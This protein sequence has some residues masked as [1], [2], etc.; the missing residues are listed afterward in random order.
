MEWCRKTRSKKPFLV[1]NKELGREFRNLFLNRLTQLV[2][3]GNIQLEDSCYIADLLGDLR[4][5]DWVAFIEGPPKQDCPPSVMLKYLTR[6]LTGGPISDRRIV[7]EKDGRVYFMARSKR[8]SEGQVMASLSRV[9]FVQQWCLHILPKDFTKT[10]FFGAW[11]GSKRRKYTD[12]CQAL[13]PSVI[14]PTLQSSRGSA[15]KKLDSPSQPTS[16]PTCP[17]CQGSMACIAQEDRPK[18][19]ELFYGPAHPAWYEWTSLG[20]CSP[21]D[22]PTNSTIGPLA[23][24]EL[25]LS[26]IIPGKCPDALEPDIFDEIIALLQ[27]ERT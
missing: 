5:Q 22:E 20:K 13:A 25:N 21:P 2:E 27:L 15:S 19:R 4:L 23:A 11:S 26:P 18:W 7:G 12:R 6:Y 16:Q 3:Q 1:D 8:K 10:R 9:E 14:L 17:H 24:T